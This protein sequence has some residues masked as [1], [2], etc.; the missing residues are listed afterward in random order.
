SFLDIAP[1]PVTRTP[2]PPEPDDKAGHRQRLRDRF[3]IGGPDALPDYELLEMI[4]FRVF[5]R[6]DTKPLAK[7][8]LARFG[9]FGDVVNAPAERL[10]E[11]EGAGE[12]VVD[13]LKLVRVAGL[14]LMRS[15]VMGRPTLS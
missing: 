5:P 14:R 13:E 9:S 7:R 11:I 2:E 8:L 4:L 6:G 15:E 3:R 10:R 1:L 12:R